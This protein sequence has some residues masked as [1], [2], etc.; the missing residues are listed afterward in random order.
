MKEQ[1]PSDGIFPNDLTTL[2]D[3]FDQLIHTALRSKYAAIDPQLPEFFIEKN[4]VLRWCIGEFIKRYLGAACYPSDRL[5][6]LI[7][8]LF[9]IKLQLYFLI[10]TEIGRYNKAIDQGYDSHNPMNTPH[11]YLTKLSI[12]QS[13]IVKSRI[14][15]ER[16]MNFVYFLEEGDE[17]E[18]LVSGNKTKSK[19][20]FQFVGKSQKWAFLLPYQNE[21]KKYDERL[22]TPEVHK[23]S[24]L[25]SALLKEQEVD[26]KEILNLINRA[27]NVIWENMI[28]IVSGD[29]PTHFT[30]IHVATERK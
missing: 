16:I 5:E 1:T 12:D 11:L 22:R 15:W 27:M 24:I 26:S 18:K 4:P 29:Q 8:K 20:F 13:V 23:N 30:D 19:V 14:L 28:S 21:L 2:A 7:Y 9:D 17:L 25:R 10:E 3:E 6:T